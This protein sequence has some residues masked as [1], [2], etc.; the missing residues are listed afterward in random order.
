MRSV[1]RTHTTSHLHRTIHTYSLCHTQCCYVVHIMSLGCDDGQKNN[2]KL[3]VLTEHNN[4]LSLSCTVVSFLYTNPSPA[5]SFSLACSLL[6]L[7]LLGNQ[8]MCLF[9]TLETQCLARRRAYLMHVSV[10]SVQLLLLFSFLYPSLACIF[11]SFF[12][13]SHSLSLSHSSFNHAKCFT[14]VNSETERSLLLRRS[15]GLW[16]CR[17]FKEPSNELERV[18]KE[19]KVVQVKCL[20]TYTCISFR[21]IRRCMH[22]GETWQV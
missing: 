12:A 13:Y 9:C 2:R 11:P 22:L 1:Q 3:R 21:R 18:R 15:R 19:P 7:S 5:S 14:S 17:L 4:D 8:L 10:D 16:D 6:F 20:L